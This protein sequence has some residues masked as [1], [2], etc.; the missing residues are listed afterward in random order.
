[1]RK[2]LFAVIAILMSL[3]SYAQTDTLRNS[4]IIEMVELKL[5]N[6]VIIAKIKNSPINF[7]T[8]IDALKALEEMGVAVDVIKAM[9][10]AKNPAQK[11]IEK[12]GVYLLTDSGEV[13]I[14]PTVFS[15]TRTNKIASVLTDDLI[16]GNV[17]AS[18]H[19]S[20]SRNAV[21]TGDCTF[22]FYFRP[23]NYGRM[24][25]ADWWFRSSKSPNEFAL[26]KLARKKDSREIKIGSKNDTFGD[27]TGVKHK[28]IC[29]FKIEEID[30]YTFKVIP[31]T[32]LEPGEYCFYYQGIVPQS[33]SKKNQSVFDFTVK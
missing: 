27:K 18:I 30:E 13:R 25:S 14:L 24:Y 3:I 8:S 2:F 15:G 29:K 17:K 22:I 32:P 16:S 28:D 31:L 6:E 20:S 4:S 12:T 21:T 9:I 7:D 26:I 10:G 19:G 23:A 11:E 1:M 5:D 33:D